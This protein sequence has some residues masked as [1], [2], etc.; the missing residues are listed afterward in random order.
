MNKK[1]G[2][3]TSS[4]DPNEIANKVKGAVVFSSSIIIFVLAKWFNIHLT[5]TDMTQ[6]GTELGAIAGAIWAVYGSILHLI[7][8]FYATKAEQV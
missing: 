3:L 7:A 5:V 6:V 4:Q 1:Y 2:A 8:W